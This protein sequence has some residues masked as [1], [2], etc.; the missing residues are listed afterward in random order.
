MKPLFNPTKIMLLLFIVSVLYGCASTSIDQ[1]KHEVSYSKQQLNNYLNEANWDKAFEFYVLPTG[2]KSRAAFSKFL[3][4]QQQ[5][6]FKTGVIKEKETIDTIEQVKYKNYNIAVLTS[7]SKFKHP[8]YENGVSVS[9]TSYAINQGDGQGKR[10]WKFF[11][12]H[13][14]NLDSVKHYIDNL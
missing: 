3:I 5:T 6:F 13:C 7:N 4:F 9:E 2:E 8:L 12:A 10:R 11:P 14:T 1:Q